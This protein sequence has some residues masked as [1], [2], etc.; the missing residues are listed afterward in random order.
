LTAIAALLTVVAGPAPSARASQNGNA[1][2]WRYVALPT[3]VSDQD[4]FLEDAIACP[5]T[6]RC[7]VGGGDD[8]QPGA[9]LMWTSDEGQTWNQDFDLPPS[10]QDEVD[11]LSCTASGSCWAVEAGTG[12]ALS[13]DGGVNWAVVPNP[14]SVQG[15]HVEPQE[16][17]CASSTCLVV[18]GHDIFA[19]TGA[20]GTLVERSTVPSTWA[21]AEIACAPKG[22]CLLLYAVGH[23]QSYSY[24]LAY[25]TDLGGS[26][27]K[28]S[29]SP[30]GPGGGISCAN[31]YDCAAVDGSMWTT[32]DGGRSWAP[33][34]LPHTDNYTGI[35]CP[36]M[37]HCAVLGDIDFE[38]SVWF[39]GNGALP[40]KQPSV[41]SPWMAVPVP[42]AVAI[43]TVSCWTAAECVIGGNSAVGGKVF[44]TADGGRTWQ[45][46]TTTAS[47]M[48]DGIQDLS[49]SADGNCFAVADNDQQL[50]G[51]TDGG[52]DWHGVV[53]PDPWQTARITPGA[54]SCTPHECIVAGDSQAS[55]LH[56][57]AALVATAD[58][59]QSWAALSV[60][61]GATA[62]FALGCS[63]RADCLLLYGAG[64]GGNAAAISADGGHQ[65]TVRSTSLDAWGLMTSA[66][67]VSATT[68]YTTGNFILKTTDA[69]RTWANV[70]VPNG[71]RNLVV[72]QI[73][74]P[75]STECWLVG[76]QGRGGAAWTVPSSSL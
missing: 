45:P 51:S 13:R 31:A 55:S 11:S 46:A 29:S 44:R 4:A 61:P 22:L 15:A 26:W 68:C 37:A 36:A 50:A 58:G 8:D 54:V 71:V 52:M 14:S 69:A 38:A 62:V 12:L 75:T 1:L 7:I 47:S 53:L 65:W 18:A 67:C 59:G 66:T 56:P 74:C 40:P 23:A 19:T 24:H 28:L 39:E 57:V 43:D 35:A 41:P 3:T 76:D 63:D 5:S 25:S 32:S 30:F 64:S 9:H 60:P 42:S 34:S 10:I 21:I 20:G 17:A 48:A 6:T 33:S 16:V 49:C 72:A 2:S 70:V 73:F 27:A